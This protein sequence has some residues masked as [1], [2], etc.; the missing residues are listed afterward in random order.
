MWNNGRIL[1]QLVLDEIEGEVKR[2]LEYIED[3]DLDSKERM[4][5]GIDYIKCALKELARKLY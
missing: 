5:E 2:L 1:R 3:I 4:Q